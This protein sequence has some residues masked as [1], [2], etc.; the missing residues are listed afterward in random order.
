[1]RNRLVLGTI[2]LTLAGAAAFDYTIAP[3]QSFFSAATWRA[4][5]VVVIPQGGLELSADTILKVDEL[6]LEGALVTNG[7]AL[8]IDVLQLTFRDNGKI[9]AFRTP[10]PQTPQP[11]DGAQGRIGSS[12]SGTGGPGQTPPKAGNGSMGEPHPLAITVYAA[13]VIG[14]P[15][16]D[17][18]GQKGGQGAHGAKGGKGG[19]GG[20]GRDGHA[21]CWGAIGINIWNGDNGGSGGQAA[22]GG[23]GGDGG[24]GGA[25]VPI[26]FITGQAL[27]GPGLVTSK[28]G[29]GGDPGQPGDPGDQGD[30]GSGGNSDSAGCWLYTKRVGGGSTGPRGPAQVQ[31]GPAGHEGTSG[32]A[33]DPSIEPLPELAAFL[34]PVQPGVI[35]RALGNLESRRLQLVDAWSQFHWTRTFLFLTL[36]TLG[37]VGR[38]NAN[39]LAADELL[40][41]SGDSLLASLIENTNQ[42]RVAK[43]IALWSSHLPESSFDLPA[44]ALRD[45]R[46][47]AQRVVSLLQ[48]IGEKQNSVTLNELLSALRN[49]LQSQFQSSLSDALESCRKYN[50]LKNEEAHTIL[51]LTSQYYVPVCDGLPD[52]R[53]F[54]NVAG[55]IQL[56]G[57]LAAQIPD[58]FAPPVYR[59]EARNVQLFSLLPHAAADGFVVIPVATNSVKAEEIQARLPGREEWVVRGVGV[60]TGF[61][62]IT[63]AADLPEIGQRLMY[64]EQTLNRIRRR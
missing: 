3:E 59:R 34:G 45:A 44:V 1:M 15:I 49:S 60:F 61:P 64:L 9:V 63:R 17:G 50:E 2:C 42:D 30:G 55:P 31:K 26:V 32:P 5:D 16:V 29:G 11:P 57:H 19:T 36:D 58:A 37:E 38:Q 10:P 12:R 8:H 35:R 54:E 52:F 24:P 27:N 40:K 56:F 4:R 48:G 46:L 62:Q 33:L 13:R 18:S 23:A 6:I 41:E 47:N 25:P 39:P 14:T 7:H 51:N 53:K 43:L 21:S 20:H 28:P 22:P